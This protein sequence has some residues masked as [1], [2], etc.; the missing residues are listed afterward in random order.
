MVCLSDNL[1]RRE[2]G[3]EKA[4]VFDASITCFTTACSSPSST[5]DVG[6]RIRGSVVEFVLHKR[7]I[8]DIDYNDQFEYHE[9]D[10]LAISEEAGETADII[11]QTVPLNGATFAIYDMTDYYHE[12][13]LLKT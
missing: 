2:Q 9:N 3:N 6:R 1:K 8:R 10:G 7:M 4:V 12:K 11:S 5:G 13:K